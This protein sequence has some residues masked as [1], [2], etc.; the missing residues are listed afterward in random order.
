MRRLRRRISH[1]FGEPKGD[2]ALTGSPERGSRIVFLCTVG[3]LTELAE[4]VQTPLENLWVFVDFRCS[5]QIGRRTRFGGVLW[6]L[7]GSGEGLG[8]AGRVV[9]GR[10][11][12]FGAAEISPVR[13]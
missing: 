2:Q 13:W 10:L 3:V 5:L 11:L 7:A 8:R 6:Y 4:N 1:N 12:G 9:Q